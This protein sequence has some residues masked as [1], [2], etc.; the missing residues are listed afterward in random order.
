[1]SGKKL[2]IG[3]WKMNGGIG[4]V[5]LAKA[6]IEGVNGVNAKNVDVA[7]CPPFTLLPLI[8][9]VV[10]HGKVSFGAQDCH[11][12]ASGAHT[13][14]I[15]AAM[16]A[17]F[18]AKFVLVGHSERRANHNEAS[19]LIAQKARAALDAGLVPVICVGETEAER[20]SGDAVP[21]VLSQIAA[22]LPIDCTPEQI[23]IAY[24]PVW[25]IGTGRV[26]STQDIE[27]MHKA[28]RDSLNSKFANAQIIPL[29][30]GGSVNAANAEQILAV[31]NVDG[32][33]VGG[34]SLKAP[35]FM[36]I[37]SAAHSIVG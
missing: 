31:N 32:A 17:E 9:Q 30:Y 22:S 16:I 15:S 11:T 6:I 1:M 7:I 28:I 21:I 37:I 2:I 26:A 34:A 23:V 25:A 4:H 14:D 29:L 19:A 8:G 10:A 20:L 27:E 24:E 33:L 12:A 5:E 13:G 18:G 35:D 3:N 36:D